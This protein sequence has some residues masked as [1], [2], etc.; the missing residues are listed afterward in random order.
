MCPEIVGGSMGPETTYDVA[1]SNGGLKVLVNYIGAEASAGLTLS[2]SADQLITA[3]AAKLTNQ[4]EK[5]LL[6]GL[7][8]LIKAIP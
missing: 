5:S 1:F 7:A 4:T 6:T 8:A 2:V 3:L